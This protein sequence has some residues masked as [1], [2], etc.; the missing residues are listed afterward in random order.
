MVHMVQIGWRPDTELSTDI[1]MVY[2]TPSG[3]G[4]EM[5]VSG[6]C[7]H[8]NSELGAQTVL[9]LSVSKGVIQ[10][11][12]ESRSSATSSSNDN[13]RP[14]PMAQAVHTGMKYVL[15]T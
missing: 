6:W 5:C 1:P 11:K 7:K 13:S 10:R 9:H 4:V 2:K 15:F 14:G 3:T 8:L 12:R